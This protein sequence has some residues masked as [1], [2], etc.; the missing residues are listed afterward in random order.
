MA[1]NNLDKSLDI[2]IKEAVRIA[3]DR[4]VAKEINRIE[5]C[6]KKVYCAYAIT[7]TVIL[8]FIGISSWQ[9]IPRVVASLIRKPTSGQ[10]AEVFL[11]G[12]ESAN[13]LADQSRIA[14]EKVNE[15]SKILTQAETDLRNT[16]QLSIDA[17][18]QVKKSS[19]LVDS[20][21][22]SLEKAQ[23]LQSELSLELKDAKQTV[24]G[25]KQNLA[26]TEKYVIEI[27]YLQYAGRNQ[28][29]NPYHQKIMD[30]LNNI[31]IASIPNL[32]ER[33][34]FIQELNAITASNQK[35]G[36]KK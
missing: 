4:E 18:S 23:K 6:R 36:T 7:I 26:Q 19:G 28:F 1:E 30:T 34:Q 9:Q 3:V 29:P 17:T 15:A 11:R 32:S 13:K 31:V 25:L 2:Q 20:A 27:E 10:L 14:Q 16:H 22:D 35:T 24:D 5:E 12:Q 21:T 8:A 33:N